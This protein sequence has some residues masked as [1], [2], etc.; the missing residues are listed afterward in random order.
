VVAV[1]SRCENLPQVAT[2]AQ[3][4]G[5]PVVAFATSGL[6]DV[7]ADGV[8]GY[9]ARPYVSAD[10]GAAISSLLNDRLKA[11][12]FSLAASERANELWSAAAVIPKILKVYEK[13]LQSHARGR[14]R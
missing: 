13:A 9:L 1:P 10:L 2:E 6:G 12:A 11:S 5:R 8:T 14:P 7:V 3:A 4:C